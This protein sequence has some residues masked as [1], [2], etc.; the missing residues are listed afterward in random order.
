M[1]PV[2]HLS[3]F[4]LRP[5][6][7]V[8]ARIA[9]QVI[10]SALLAFFTSPLLRA[11]TLYWDI[12]GKT[13]GAGGATPAGTW[14]TSGGANRAWT[15]SSAGTLKATSNWIAAAD[16][17]FSAGTDA[18]G[19]YTVTVT[20]TQD[21]S[22]I[23]VTDGSPTLSSGIIN[24]SDP[25]PDILVAAGSALVFSSA[26]TSASNNLNLGSATF[27]GTTV[28]S[29]N[30][31][32]SGTV[33]LAGGTLQLSGSSYSFGTLNITGDSTID[34][35]GST[36]L[37]VTTFN[38]STGVTLTIQNWAGAVDYFYATNWT[39]ATPDLSNNLNAAPM[40]QV[41]FN[42][43][44]ATD[45]GWDSYNNEIRPNVPEPAAYGAL[46][47]GTLTAF[48]AWHRRRVIA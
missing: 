10:A 18:T 5:T 36:T 28:F 44:A 29:A 4:R 12:N 27:T 7:R 14:S 31:T 35:A 30:T 43:F 17:V 39:G 8:A 42:G 15:T 32:L 48:L 9:A 40:N 22:S 45:S 33:N 13:A 26:L 6:S 21:V 41:V 11:Q 47:L 3:T 34:F 19:A 24:F 1:T 38:I 46:L 16:A 2:Y 37:N 25:T 23:T 20:G